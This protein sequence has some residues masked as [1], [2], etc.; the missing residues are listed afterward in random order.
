MPWR[1]LL[2]FLLLSFVLLILPFVQALFSLN[3]D[4]RGDLNMENRYRMTGQVEGGRGDYLL[5]AEVT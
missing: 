4:P 5:P 3:V 1:L 2:C